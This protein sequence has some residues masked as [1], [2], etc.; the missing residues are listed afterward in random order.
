MTEKDKYI[1]D[2][3]LHGVKMYS[4][5][6]K[7]VWKFR[8][9]SLSLN[10]LDGLPAEIQFPRG[11]AYSMHVADVIKP[12]GFSPS[13]KRIWGYGESYPVFV[14]AFRQMEDQ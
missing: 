3:T 8:K 2:N 10:M 13:G 12:V 1:D 7:C 14:R 9:Y 11:L 4:G 6:R 5:V